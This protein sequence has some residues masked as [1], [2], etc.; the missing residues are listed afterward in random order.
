M[1][2]NEILARTGET[3]ERARAQAPLAELEARARE[4]PPPRDFWA[5]LRGAGGGGAPRRAPAVIAEVKRRS[6]SAGWIREG[7]DAAEIAARY[8]AAG[9]AALS[10]LTDEPFFGGALEDLRRAR[11]ATSLPVLRKDFVIDRY[12]V[13]EARAAGA[14]AIL[15]IVSALDDERLV[16]LQA[17][18]ARW[19]MDVLVEAHDPA[20][21]RRALSA[22]AR[23]IGINHRDLRTFQVD[24]TLAARMRPEIP[25]GRI[26]V[27]ESGIKTPADVAR[28][29]DAAIDAILVGETLMR[30]PDP[31]TAL[32]E[33]LGEP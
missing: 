9:A 5:A 1:I 22:A 27:A 26:V 18:A 15:L 8:Q 19:G 16:S 31:G 4:A 13:V 23:I 3:V 14:D 21:V 17:E 2:L 7:A 25:A 29:R 30:A 32:K 20:E 33:L 28:L 24:T 6:P 12:Q 11:A 10:V